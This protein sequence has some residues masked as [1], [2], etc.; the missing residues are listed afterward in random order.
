MMEY[1][2]VQ[3][4]EQPPQN[5]AEQPPV[6]VKA[7]DDL[8]ALRYIPISHARAWDRN[9]KLHDLQKLVESIETYGFKDPPAYDVQLDAFVEGNGRTEA[10]QWMARHGRQR[11]R[12]IAIDVQTGEWCMPVLFGVDAASR[13]M[14]ERSEI[15]TQLFDLAELTRFAIVRKSTGNV[16]TMQF[17]MAIDAQCQS[18][19]NLIPQIGVID[20]ALD[21]VG[22]KRPTTLAA[23]LAGVIISLENSLSPRLILA[24]AI[25]NL[26]FRLRTPP[27]RVFVPPPPHRI[28]PHRLSPC[29]I[30]MS[31]LNPLHKSSAIRRTLC[32]FRRALPLSFTP[33]LRPGPSRNPLFPQCTKRR[34]SIALQRFFA[35]YGTATCNRA[36]FCVLSASNN[37]V[38]TFSGTYSHNPPTNIAI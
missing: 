9:P 8:L 36:I 26:P 23:M 2:T 35:L 15:E 16:M 28:V 18:V 13:L 14:A 22:M 5:L 19:T 11:P 24:A 3:Q 17:T 34:I 30:F 27:I 7:G 32:A 29:R 10:L 6:E 31:T 33:F 20:P 1:W 37:T 12:G 21:M 38:A 4:S 25:Q